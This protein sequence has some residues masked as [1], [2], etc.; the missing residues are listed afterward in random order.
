MKVI[1]HKCENCGFELS[2][3]YQT[4][5]WVW[6]GGTVQIITGRSD[7][8]QAVLPS[9]TTNLREDDHD[10]CSVKCLVAAVEDLQRAADK[11]TTSSGT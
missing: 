8:L 10:F 11:L 9:Q 6:I 2:N 5:N 7:N 1:T 3:P 4:R